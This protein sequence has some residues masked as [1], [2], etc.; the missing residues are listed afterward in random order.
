MKQENWQYSNDV[1]GLPFV[2]NCRWRYS[3]HYCQ[4]WI[5]EL[6]ILFL[7]HMF[8]TLFTVFVYF[9][10]KIVIEGLLAVIFFHLFFSGAVERKFSYFALT[11]LQRAPS[12]VTSVLVL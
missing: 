12:R 11:L 6:S 1:K 9:C 4:Y 8:Y 2:N 3:V 10:S 7:R 5:W